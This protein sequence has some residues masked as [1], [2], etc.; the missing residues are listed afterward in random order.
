MVI[1]MIACVLVLIAICDIRY[2]LI[3][4]WLV[5]LLALLSL[6]PLLE[7]QMNWQNACLGS[8]LG[9]GLLW[10]LRWASHGG[11]GLGDVK[12]AA[13]LGLWLGWENILLCLLTASLLGVLYGSGMLLCH[14]MERNTPI[15]FGPFLAIGAWLAWCEGDCIRSFME[16]VLW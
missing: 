4:D 10:I 13:A 14:R 6:V 7:G 5:V 1:K 16:Q 11:L 15:P 3:Y 9:C 8:A 2:G 12:M